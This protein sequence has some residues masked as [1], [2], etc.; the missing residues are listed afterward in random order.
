MKKISHIL[1][2]GILFLAAASCQPE[3]FER[4]PANNVTEGNFYQ[5]EADFN[6]GVYCCYAKLKTQMSYYL[7]ELAYR[8]DECI[9]ESMAVST[10]DRYD[11]DNFAE[12][13]SNGII[14]NIWAAWYNGIYRCNDV[15][16]HAEGKDYAKLP[17]YKAECLFIRSWYLFMLYQTFGVVP[18][19]TRVLTPAEAMT[20]GRCTD[21]EMY[22]RLTED[23][24]EAIAGLP[25]TRSAEKA[26]VTKIAAQMLLGRVYLKY[27]KYAEAQQ[28]IGDALDDPNFGLMGS[29]AAAFDV[30]NKMNKE[31]IFALCYNKSIPDVGHGYWYSSNTAVEADRRNP[32]PDFKKIYTTQDNRFDLINGY[33]KISS[34][35]YAMKKWYDTYDATNTTQ[36]GNDFPMMRYADLVLM[37]AE[38]VGLGGDIP[39]ALPYLNRTRQRAGLPALT[40]ADVPSREVFVQELA[41]ERGRELALEG[42]RWHD[43]VR[44]GLAVNYF[45]SLGYTLD[46]HELILPLPRAQLEIYNNTDI[47]WQNP[48]YNSNY[49]K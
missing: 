7:T 3:F 39:N 18:I 30:N 2:F 21:E 29:T 32:T 49:S 40:S 43:L 41:D 33:V 20:L 25:E 12:V 26:R 4:Y 17:Q 42:C 13:E 11:L 1:T 23:L 37:M 45:R 38:A 15:L 28:V 19:P 9:L 35:V 14:A 8:S 5:T 46:E 48:G 22:T 10:Q 36:V 44:L 27:G 24:K 34:S 47:L 6:Q 31:I 16:D